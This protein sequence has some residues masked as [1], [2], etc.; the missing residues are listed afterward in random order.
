VNSVLSDAVDQIVVSPISR[1]AAQSGGG[2]GGFLA[3]GV[4]ATAE[5]GKQVYLPELSREVEQFVVTGSVPDQ[6]QND[7]FGIAVGSEFLRTLATSQLTY[8]GISETRKISNDLALV[9][10]RVQSASS[11]SQ[12]QQT[13]PANSQYP[14]LRIIPAEESP[15]LVTLKLRPAGSHWQIVGVENLPELAKQ[16]VN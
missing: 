15:V 10:V 12:P 11:N 8:G 7:A 6:S 2:L 3:A 13:A 16:L 9:T 14:S 4:A 1:S 5:A